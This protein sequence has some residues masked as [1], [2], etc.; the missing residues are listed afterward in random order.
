M[1]ISEININAIL[2]FA[3]LLIVLRILAQLMLANVGSKWVWRTGIR[4]AA[5]VSGALGFFLIPAA[6]ALQATRV[7]RLTLGD[8]IVITLCIGLGYHYCR[9]VIAER[10]PVSIQNK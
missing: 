9:T 2:S 7:Q 6:L 10:R 8:I 4:H 3:C 5:L 1:S